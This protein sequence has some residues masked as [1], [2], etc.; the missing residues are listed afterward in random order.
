MTKPGTRVG[1]V[2]SANKDEVKFLGFGLYVGDEKPPGDIVFFGG[3]LSEIYERQP[4]FSRDYTN[5]KIQLDNG[6]V[7]WGCECWWGPE[8]EVKKRFLSDGRKVVE[9]RMEPIREEARA[10]IR[11]EKSG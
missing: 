5:P 1:A 7:V 11:K 3:L 6:D 8:E 10:E 4:E 9:V 2:L